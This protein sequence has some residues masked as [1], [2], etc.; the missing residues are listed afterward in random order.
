M[1]P[2]PLTRLRL[3]AGL[4]HP[5]Y[6]RLIADTHALLG[7]GTMAAR[8]E[9]VS[10][11]ESGR[12][13]P[14]LTTQ[15]AIAHVHRIPQEFVHQLGWPHWLHLATDGAPLLEE[16][17]DTGGA[18]EIARRVVATD[19]APAPGHLAVTGP[20][21]RVL[22]ARA[23]A[24]LTCP[25]PAEAHRPD[26]AP[27]D[28][29]L[30]DGAESRLRHLEVPE[31]AAHQAPATAPPLTPAALLSAAAAEHR[32]AVHLATHSATSATTGARLL[33]LLRRTAALCAI[34]CSSTG[35]EGR[36]EWYGLA[37][38]RAATASRES[39]HVAAAFSHL[40]LRHLSA[41]D[42]ADALFLLDVAR[43][44]MT[45]PS[46]HFTASLYAKRAVAQ[47]RLGDT[48]G[49]LR[50]LDR[51]DRAAARA[52][53]APCPYGE[54]VDEQKM[55]FGRAKVWKELG[56]PRRALTGFAPL[57]ALV[58]T[59]AHMSPQTAFRL[60][61]PIDAQLALND[62]DAAAHGLQQAVTLTGVLPPGLVRQYRR[63]FAPHSGHRLVGP[64]WS[65][66]TT[67]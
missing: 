63:R 9:K 32:F 5:A 14:D 34:L 33:A 42:P 46:H 20:A 22:A 39:L 8:R 23:R 15:L 65:F 37:A 43:S 11:W 57:T 3:A 25:Q 35:E 64:L 6:A 4:S 56:D 48:A 60:L 27:F 1:A 62:L 30:L 50:A 18:V 16:P 10:R 41:G 36:A 52:G 2:H 55:L 13:T 40:A 59:R 58:D 26:L 53:D 38:L 44:L 54:H 29:R 67:A 7:H 61:Q 49:S 47:A 17:W 66:L 28:P 12:V 45:E 19:R 51:A 21:L 31:W 24:A